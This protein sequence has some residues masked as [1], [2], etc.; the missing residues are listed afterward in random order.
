M[1]VTIND[2]AKLAGV[3]KSTVS[4]YLNGGY[5]SEKNK[6][7]IAKAIER[8]NY[9]TNL[10]ARG[11]KNKKSYL[12]AVIVPRLDS[13]TVMQMLEGMNQVLKDYPYQMIIIPKTSIDE[14]EVTYLQ[15]MLQQ[16][17]DGIIVSAHH[18]SE[19]HI[20]L[21]EKSTVPIIFT[22]QEHPKVD[23][24]VIDD[25]QIGVL[26]G[27]Y[28]NQLNAKEIL[29]LGV[30]ADDISVGVKRKNGILSTL[31]KQKNVTTVETGFR[32][33]QAYETMKELSLKHCPD[34]IIGATDNIALGAMKFAMESD[35]KIPQDLQVIGVGNYDMSQF[36][37]PTLTTVSIDYIQFGHQTMKCLLHKMGEL[38]EVNEPFAID[39]ELIQRNSTILPTK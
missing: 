28:V 29:Y 25:F 20:E 26:I 3:A 31:S 19:R 35:I 27:N 1:Q 9:T 10:F 24:L 15:K 5:V 2:V 21:A 17:V 34:L 30:P 39:Y 23:S 8:T 16:G 6:L 32:M 18:I 12:I 33:Q 37:V 11:L 14:D 7:A 22:G 13:F 38:S 36:I 4:R